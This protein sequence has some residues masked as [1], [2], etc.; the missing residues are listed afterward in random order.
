M[1]SRRSKR[2]EMIEAINWAGREL[3]TAGIM[4]HSVVAERLGLN[5]TDHKALDLIV[6]SGPMTAGQLAEST[7]LTTGAVTG[8]IDRLEKADL[9]H[10]ERDPNDRRRVIIRPTLDPQR[11][12]EIASLFESMARSM[13]RMASRYSDEELK[14]ILDYM[15]R[16]REILQQEAI[17]LRSN[18]EPA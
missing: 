13:S 18:G 4:F 17:K 8:I 3:S 16:S 14:T 6:R 9:V 5:T 11:M 10:R 15:V 2:V 12:Q 1:S 7:G